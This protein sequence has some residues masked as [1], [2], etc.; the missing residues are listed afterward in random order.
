MG[1]WYL[2]AAVYIVCL[3]LA[4]LHARERLFKV[5]EWVNVVPAMWTMLVMVRYIAAPLSHDA[6]ERIYG[7]I[8]F[9]PSAVVV[10]SSVWSALA[11][12]LGRI[13]V[14]FGWCVNLAVFS[15]MVFVFVY[16]MTHP[17]WGS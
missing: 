13:V 17:I 6:G 11:S 14:W 4:F 8:V 1:V 9:W 5:A 2:M 15:F 16:F 10:V 7:T 12:R 3:L